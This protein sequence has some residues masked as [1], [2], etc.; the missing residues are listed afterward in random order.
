MNENGEQRIPAIAV[1]WNG[2]T[3]TVHLQYGA[4][5]KNTDFVICLLQMAV[6]ALE[7]KRKLEQMQALQH[8]AAEQQRVQKLM[9]TLKR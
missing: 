3:Q 1:G 5:F 4:E 6:R 8:A 9:E 7:D 2:E